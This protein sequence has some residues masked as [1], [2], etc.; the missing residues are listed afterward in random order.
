MSISGSP[1]LPNVMAIELLRERIAGLRPD[2]VQ[3]VLHVIDAFRTSEKYSPV[4][5]IEGL[6]KG[7]DVSAE[8]I[9]DARSEMQSRALRVDLT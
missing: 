9:D 1:T 2:Q 3:A 6:W 8:E 7:V 5:S 4:K